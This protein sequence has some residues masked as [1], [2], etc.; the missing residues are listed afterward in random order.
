V[1][2][3]GVG[4]AVLGVVAG[5]VVGGAHAQDATA[6]PARAD[7]WDTD[8][9]GP[10]DLTRTWKLDPQAP[11]ATFKYP[12]AIVT[13]EGHRALRLRTERETMSI[14]RALRVDLKRTPRLVWDWK[15]LILPEG[16][17]VRRPRHND[18]AARVT[19]LFTGFKS[20]VY[21]WDTQA[22]VGT[23]V[24]P[25]AFATVDRAL[26]VV[27]SGTDG[28]GR[29]QHEQRDVRGDYRRIFEEEPRAV[30][31]IS[32]ESHSDDVRSHSEALIGTIRFE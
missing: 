14:W 15:V 1:R 24:R 7:T 16:G 32:L 21:V 22:P 17:D 4:L 28:L 29:W 11:S 26:I 18:Q 10:L 23:E 31:W 12:P 19:V 13:D 20:L 5:A 2:A 6:P 9:E 8:R 25:E 30:K 3:L 27:R